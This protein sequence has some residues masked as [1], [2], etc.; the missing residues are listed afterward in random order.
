MEK[1]RR[2]AAVMLARQQANTLMM[3]AKYTTIAAQLKPALAATSPNGAGLL[4]SALMSPMPSTTKY[5]M[6]VKN[7]PANA[8]QPITE[9]GMLRLGFLDSLASVAALSKPTK[10]KITKGSAE[11]TLPRLNVF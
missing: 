5:A 9:R 4:A 11:N 8:A 1:S 3:A 10:L 2:D 6:K 7:T